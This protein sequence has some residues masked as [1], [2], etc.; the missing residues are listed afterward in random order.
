[1]AILGSWRHSDLIVREAGSNIEPP[2]YE[3]LDSPSR[4]HPR[5][6]TPLDLWEG[7]SEE[8]RANFGGRN[9][10]RL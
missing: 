10:A 8:V 2:D 4:Q 5:Y 6:A 1:M 3:P 7:W 9:D